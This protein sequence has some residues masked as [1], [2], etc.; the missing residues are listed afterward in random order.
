[1]AEKLISMPG[2]QLNSVTLAFKGDCRYLEQDFLDQ[3]IENNL[4][5]TRFALFLGAIFFAVFG[6]LDVKLAPEQ[7]EIL[8]VIRYGVICP[9]VLGGVL[10]S[11]SKAFKR[12]MQGCLMVLTIVAGSS[13][14]AM[15]ALTQP[16]ASFSYYAGIILV[17]M[18]SYGFIKARFIWATVAGWV[19]VAV[20]ET[21]AIWVIQ[22]PGPVLLNNN[23]FFIGANII[24]MFVCYSI[25]SYTRKNFYMARRLESEQQ[26]V[27][28]LNQD[29]EQRVQERTAEI[30]QTNQKLE[31]E[32]DAHN[33][34]K[35][36]KGIL[37]EQ[38]NQAQKMEAIGTLA[39]GIAHDFNNILSAI[40]GYSELAQSNVPE[41][42]RTYENLEKVLT[43]S[44][45]ARDLVK[46][47][48]TFSRHEQGQSK[49]P[50]LL[51]SIVK[52]IQKLLRATLPATI[53]I[54]HSL[55]EDIGHITG[56]PDQIH[57]LLMNLCT[58]AAQAMAENGGIL[59][60]GL[61]RLVLTEPEA[62]SNDNLDPGQYVKLTVKDSGHGMDEATAKRIFEP[63]FTTKAKEKGTGLGLSIVH[64]IVRSHNAYIDVQS[65]PEKGTVFQIFF[66]RIDAN[67]KLEIISNDPPKRGT[68][69]ILIVDDENIIAEMVQDMLSSL[70]YDTIA[71][72]QS[73]EALVLFQK[74]PT[75]FDLV[76][77]DT[78]MP[79]MTGDALASEMLSLNPEIPIILT[80][81]YSER[82]SSEK[83]KSLGIRSFIM[84][85]LRI[86][87]LA[88]EIRR[89]L[90]ES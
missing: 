58:N 18:M 80:T 62:I 43:S 24:G 35:K 36:Q 72:T 55:P 53:E 77:T 65:K 5:H 56:S 21:V 49:K 4:R 45:R 69:R 22:T 23:F 14:T 63:Y 81:G 84:K 37:K 59:E 50:L 6:Y 20:Y 47:I 89:A 33:R 86:K 32:I 83:A 68:E 28:R 60:I 27:I 67:I 10:F 79:Q 11:Y 8:W 34:E 66:P 38:L 78:T 1:M 82:I 51:S 7:K 52:E 31:E 40:I 61:D 64:G 39:G 75:A 70:G 73:P 15:I 74:D 9:S 19:N 12:C 17:F 46:Q 90:D 2:I 26:N 16:P 87:T 30:G 42:S 88:D 54:R 85:P 29:L 25:E 48:L 57:R 41:G 76:I 44:A 71:M 13:I 3:Y